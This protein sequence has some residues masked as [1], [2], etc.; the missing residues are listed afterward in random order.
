MSADSSR[1]VNHVISCL[2]SQY[3]SLGTQLSFYSFNAYSC[4]HYNSSVGTNVCIKKQNE[5]I[6]SFTGVMY[7]P[8]WPSSH[9]LALRP[10]PESQWRYVRCSRWNWISSFP[11]RTVAADPRHLQSLVPIPEGA[12]GLKPAPEIGALPHLASRPSSRVPHS[13]SFH[14]ETSRPVDMASVDSPLISFFF[15]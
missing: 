9:G 2:Y 5:Y 8:S 12:V 6:H 13:L 10:A 11:N 4:Q 3:N 1:E 15:F 7:N 14:L